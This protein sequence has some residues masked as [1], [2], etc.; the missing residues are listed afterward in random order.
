[1]ALW[2]P[3]E[4]A[5]RCS[6]VVPSISSMVMSG[7]AIP[8]LSGGSALGRPVG[9]R[10]N[11]ETGQQRRGDEVLADERDECHRRGLAEGLDHLAVEVVW[12][13][14]VAHDRHGEPMGELGLW[15]DA[16]RLVSGGT[17]CV[18]VLVPDPRF[19]SGQ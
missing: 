15:A 1:M 6:T 16:S 3:S 9:R 4:I 2:M 7:M 17:K 19:S 10:R 12:H 13:V 8:L 5:L 18:Y 14:V 11:A